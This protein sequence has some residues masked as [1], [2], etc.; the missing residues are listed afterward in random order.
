MRDCSPTYFLFGIVNKILHEVMF[1][2]LGHPRGSWNVSLIFVAK[3]LL[4]YFPFVYV[5]L[6]MSMLWGWGF[7]VQKNQLANFVKL[8]IELLNFRMKNWWANIVTFA[9]STC[10]TRHTSQTHWKPWLRLTPSWTLCADGEKW[11]KWGLN[12]GDSCPINGSICAYFDKNHS[13]ELC[14]NFRATKGDHVV[15]LYNPCIN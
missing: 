8:G 3:I 11:S 1:L 5:D 15:Y 7:F 10:E 14:E 2:L 12:Q 4:L 13:I 6:T 9:L